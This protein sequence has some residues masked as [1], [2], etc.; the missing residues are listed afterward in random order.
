M[1]QASISDLSTANVQFELATMNADV[2]YRNAVADNLKAMA[3]RRKAAEERDL[4]SDGL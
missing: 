3:A 4:S 1:L 2:A